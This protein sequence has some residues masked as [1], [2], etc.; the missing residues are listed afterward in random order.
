MKKNMIN[1]EWSVLCTNAI[2]DNDT[3]NISLFNVIEQVKLDVNL[4][5]DKEWDEKTGD[6]FPVN[7]ILV[8]RLRKMVDEKKLVKGNL[9]IDLI[10]P[11][12]KPLGS[13]EQDFELIDGV[14]NMRMRVGIEGLKITKSG[15]YYFVVNLK[16]ESEEKYKKVYS[17]PLKVN[18]NIKKNDAN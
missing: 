1:H 14:D 8:T 3:N 15:I 17:L 4:K 13:F 16:E 10:S 7:M 11:D 12:K 6:N 18:L 9:K 2:V 5:D